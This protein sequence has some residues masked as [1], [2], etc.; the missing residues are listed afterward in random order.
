MDHKFCY[1]YSNLTYVRTYNTA[2]GIRKKTCINEIMNLYIRITN[3]LIV[4]DKFFVRRG[5]LI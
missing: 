5:V 2:F 1:C 4:Y 3:H